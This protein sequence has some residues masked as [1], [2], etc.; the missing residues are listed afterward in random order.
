MKH[1]RLP[2]I[3]VAVMLL[4]GACSSSGSDAPETPRYT[5]VSD[6]TIFAS[7]RAIP[8]VE[9]ADLSFNGTAPSHSYLARITVASDVDAQSVLDAVYAQLWQGRRGAD[10]TLEAQQG[11][12][13]VRLDAFEGG[14]VTRRLLEE[15]YGPQPG[16]GT[17]LE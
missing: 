2:L 13:V 7:I 12:A 6:E 10:I 15:R 5:P 14:P 11:G 16:D 9:R 3:V 1:L 17:P 4:A 8:G